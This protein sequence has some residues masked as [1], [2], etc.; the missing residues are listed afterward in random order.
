MRSL[1]QNKNIQNYFM[2]ITYKIIP[3]KQQPYKLMTITS[4]NEIENTTNV[5]CLIGI[6]YEDAISIYNALNYLKTF[7][8]FIP[9]IVHI[10]FSLSE[11]KALLNENLYEEKPIIISCFFHFT[12]AIF[13]KM[14]EFKLVKKRLTKKAFAILRNVELICF[15]NP[16]IIPNY[17]NFLK[18]NLKEENEILLF[19][20]LKKNWINKDYHIYNYYTLINNKTA[21][22]E[23][24]MNHFY[25]TNNIAESFHAKLNYYIPKRKITGNDFLVALQSILNF[26][27]IK[28]NK[29]IRKDF[30]TRTLIKIALSISDSNFN[31]I[32]YDYFKNEELK[33]I[34]KDINLYDYNVA[35]N[36]LKSVNDLEE[37]SNKEEINTE[38]FNDIS[39]YNNDINII[40]IND[41]DEEE[42]NSNSIENENDEQNNTKE[43][44]FEILLEDSNRSNTLLL[45]RLLKKD[46]M[47]NYKYIIDDIRKKS[48]RKSIEDDDLGK[49]KNA[50]KKVKKKYNYPKD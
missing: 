34:C 8:N 39:N 4:V 17:A 33:I 20:Y 47:D 26:N 10:D 5:C 49:L 2:D 1:L 15:L 18:N 6:I 3:K 24:I 42:E 48:K 29:I 50:P 11:R 27:E 45:D 31:W 22:I 38:A 44:N 19:N 32:T 37:E 35:D 41:N 13:R 7:F 36:I 14:K 25:I 23:N 43:S 46:N 21:N 12:Q 16:Q 28:N 40:S 9:K 30:V